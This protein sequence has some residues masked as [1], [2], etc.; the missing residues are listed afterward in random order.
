M[1]FLRQQLR[2]T[3]SARE[4]TGGPFQPPSSAVATQGLPHGV[5]GPVVLCPGLCPTL[6]TSS[7]HPC[8]YRKPVCERRE[9]GGQKSPED[10]LCLGG[11][12]PVLTP[13]WTLIFGGILGHSALFSGPQS[14]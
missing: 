5:W 10:R 1:C 8:P 13:V 2:A 6:V 3:Y 9:C 11:R 4:G 7:P 14:P 12:K